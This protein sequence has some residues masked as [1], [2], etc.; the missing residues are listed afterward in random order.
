MKN[1]KYPEPTTNEPDMEELEEMAWDGIA[2][3]TDGCEVEPDGVC[4][5]GY[6]SWLIELGLI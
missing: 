4:Q 3:A 2:L 5:H 1:N 6:P